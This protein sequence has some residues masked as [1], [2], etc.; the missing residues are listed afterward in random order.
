MGAE[1][2]KLTVFEAITASYETLAE[3]LVWPYEDGYEEG[4][5][6]S[7]LFGYEKEFFS[8]SEA[9]AATVAKLKEVVEK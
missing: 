1:E 5:C 6:G 8:K 3:K 7:T 2:T 9:I 4:Y